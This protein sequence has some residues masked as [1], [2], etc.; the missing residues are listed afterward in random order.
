MDAPYAKLE[1]VRPGIARVLAHNPSAFTYY[2]TQTYLAGEREVAV[3]DPGPDLPEHLD[4]LEQAIDGREVVA[5]MCTHTH[6]DHSPAA[7]PLA[8]MI[9]T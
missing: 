3:I 6:R 9:S 2:G 4:A 5:V 7:R 8:A 1:Q